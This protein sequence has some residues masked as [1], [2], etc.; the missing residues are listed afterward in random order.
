QLPSSTLFPYTTLFR[1]KRYKVGDVK[2]AGDLVVDEEQLKPLLIVRKGQIFSQQLMTYTSDLLT[3]RLGNEGYT[4]AEVNGFTEVNDE[5]DTVDI[6]FFVD[7]GKKVYV[8][9]IT[10]AGNH[11]TTDEVLRREMRQF[12]TAPANS[13]L[14]DL[15]KSRLQRLGFFSVVDADT[16]RI[17]GVDDLVDVTYK[18]EEQPSG[19]IGA[20]IGYSDA[21][22]VI[23][24]ANVSQD[25]CR[26]SGHRVSFALSRGE[27]GDADSF[28]HY[29]PYYTLD[30][31]SRGF[32]LF[33]SA[34]DYDETTVASY[35]ADRAGATVTY[36]YPISEYARL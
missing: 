7:P 24:G 12:E 10:Y 35:A 5:D 22:G 29:T 11:K 36:G 32:C 3:R 20:N 16:Q 15:S 13:A 4:F 8:R 6:T 17:P 21:S 18:V 28:S 19:S 25:T 27:V 9:R 1:S 34:I 14:I 2:L 26:G 30:G 33:Y 23:F 31:V